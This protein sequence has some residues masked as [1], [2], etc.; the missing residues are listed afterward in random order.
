[1]GVRAVLSSPLIYESFQRLVGGTEM[2]ERCLDLLDIKAGQRVLD[3][4]CGPAYYVKNLPSVEYFGFDTNARYIEHAQKKF[5]DRGTFRCEVFSED[6]ATGLGKFDRV[7]L[8][9][10]LHHLTDQECH[11]LLSLIGRVL[12]PGGVVLALDTVVHDGQTWFERKLA[13]GDRGEHVR[14]GAGFEALG[15]AHFE[16][17]DGRLAEPSWVPAVHFIMKLSSPL[18]K[19]NAPLAQ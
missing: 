11:D 7:L 19:D 12:A 8:M 18:R 17:V 15:R 2:R 13:L 4:G 10:L 9:G 6:S 1:M 16:T 3:V 14:E 5:G